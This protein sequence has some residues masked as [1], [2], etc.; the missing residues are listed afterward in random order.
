MKRPTSRLVYTVLCPVDFSKTSRTAL[1]CAATIARR[2]HGR[3]V[4]LFVNDPLLVAAAAAA[5]DRRARVATS[6]RELKQFVS[7]A[8]KGQ[9][10][11]PALCQVAVGVPPLEIL[12]VARRLSC[13]VMV[14]GTSGV[15]GVGRLFFGS[16]IDRVLR[17]TTI[18]VVAVPPATIPAPPRIPGL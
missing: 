6:T 5:A 10:A 1:R 9:P 17:A 7:R 8:L 12:K 11:S 15:G 4:V 2:F 16:T 14:M 13:D 18:P 3:L